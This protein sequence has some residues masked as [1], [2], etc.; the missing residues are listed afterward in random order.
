M[1]VERRE[2]QGRK[3]GGAVVIF[4]AVSHFFFLPPH[5]SAVVLDAELEPTVLRPWTGHPKLLSAL[6][7]GVEE[8]ALIPSCHFLDPVVQVDVALGEFLVACTD[9]SLVSVLDLLDRAFLLCLD[10]LEV[11]VRPLSEDI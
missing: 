10:G 5:L 3:K 11:V 7:C 6:P 4:V 9:L 1:Q 8:P 2:D